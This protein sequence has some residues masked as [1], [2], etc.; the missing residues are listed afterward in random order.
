MIKSKRFQAILKSKR[1]FLIRKDT[2]PRFQTTQESIEHYLKEYYPERLERYERYL[3]LLDLSCRRHKEDM[4]NNILDRY[5]SLGFLA[6]V[7]KVIGVI[8]KYPE[9]LFAFDKSKPVVLNRVD[10]KLCAPEIYR[11][12]IIKDF[13]NQRIEYVQL[14]VYEHS[15]W[16]RTYVNG[17]LSMDFFKIVSGPIE[18]R[19]FETIFA[20]AA[21]NMLPQ[22]YKKHLNDRE[23][24][25][26]K[27]TTKHTLRCIYTLDPVYF[28]LVNQ[29]AK[30][31][32][33]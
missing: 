3:Y 6:T 27:E 10:A 18:L 16:K 11:S 17:V 23:L 24:T 8:S 12:P 19:K 21:C 22:M 1:Q 13:K 33:P 28:M 4:F 15:G 26:V 32:M 25:K 2:L 20:W 31:L 9:I 14:Y 30:L 7:D 29:T 5:F